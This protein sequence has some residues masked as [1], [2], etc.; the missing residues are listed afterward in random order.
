L[1]H[2]ARLIG[3]AITCA[4][5]FG[6]LWFLREIFVLTK[7]LGIGSR[8]VHGSGRRLGVGVVVVGVAGLVGLAG[9]KPCATA[10][11]ATATLAQSRVTPPGVTGVSF[12]KAQRYKD[13][14]GKEMCAIVEPVADPP[15]FAR[16]VTEISY[17][18]YLQP[19]VVKSA[20]TQIVAPGGQGDLRRE[21]CNVFTLVPGGFSQTQL[22][23]TISRADRKPLLPGTYTLRIAVDG[24]LSEV[25]FA[26]K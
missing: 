17:G 8:R 4:F 15:V 11:P 10:M 13:T 18:V 20:S 16:G 26:I 3:P 2:R 23:G 22:G 19:R 7:N 14:S 24:Q 6:L 21:P 25:P 5:F 1:T 12:G 9:L